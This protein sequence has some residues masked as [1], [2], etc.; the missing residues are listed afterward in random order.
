MHFCFHKMFQSYMCWHADDVKYADPDKLL[1]VKLVKQRS[2]Q[3]TKTPA[4][5]SIGG[6]VVK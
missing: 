4:L 5:R 3:V 2:T 6:L 1:D